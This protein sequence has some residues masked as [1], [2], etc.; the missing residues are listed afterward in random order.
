MGQ[1]CNYNFYIILFI[2]F[3]IPSHFIIAQSTSLDFQT[4]NEV[5]HDQYFDVRNISENH[6][7]YQFDFCEGDLSLT[8]TL[9]TKEETPFNVPIGTSLIQ[10]GGKWY[11]FVCSMND[12]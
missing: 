6:S 8:P 1:S 2:L 12:N 10:S 11:G 9:T 3:L 4:P 7:S 5:C